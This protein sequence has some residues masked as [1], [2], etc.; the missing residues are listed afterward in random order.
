MHFRKNFQ[1]NKKK[2]TLIFGN[3]FFYFDPQKICM[4]LILWKYQIFEIHS[5]VC[6]PYVYIKLHKKTTSY[7]VHS[8]LKL[9][10]KCNFKSTKTHYM[11]FQKWQK[12]NFCIRKKSENCIFGSFKL[13]S[14]A[15][16]WLFAIFEIAKDVFLYFWNWT[17]F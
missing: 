16:N 9:E 1:Q 3:F 8:A 5:A 17:F 10:K 7:M 12:I 4:H 2:I 11:H 14:S 6:G 13:F 15:K